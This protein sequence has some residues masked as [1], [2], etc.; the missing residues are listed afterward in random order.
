MK[1]ETIKAKTPATANIWRSFTHSEEISGR[2]FS[3]GSSWFISAPIVT[4]FTGG[5]KG[6]GRR[7]GGSSSGSPFL[8]CS[9]RTSTRKPWALRGNADVA[10]RLHSGTKKW[11]SE[12]RRAWSWRASTRCRKQAGSRWGAHEASSYLTGN[13]YVTGQENTF[14]NITSCFQSSGA[15]STFWFRGA[16]LSVNT[17][18]N[19]VLIQIWS[20][21][22]K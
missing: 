18:D 6:R 12:P 10:N 14:F 7:G 1:N 19:S 15:F 3:A 11:G 8:F 17:H 9:S 21:L 4:V 5:R 13:Q 22:A 16:P 20:N 2:D